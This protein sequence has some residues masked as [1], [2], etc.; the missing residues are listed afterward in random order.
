MEVTSLHCY[1]NDDTLLKAALMNMIASFPPVGAILPVKRVLIPRYCKFVMD[2][3]KSSTCS[4]PLFVSLLLDIVS[5]WPSYAED[6]ETIGPV[7]EA[8]NAGKERDKVCCLIHF[9]FRNVELLHGKRLVERMLGFITI[10]R[11]GLSESE[12]EDAL[13]T[14][15]DVLDDVRCSY[16]LL[17][18][19]NISSVSHPLSLK[20]YPLV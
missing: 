15:D 6:S 16:L 18:I 8:L 12:L 9:I 4:N 20:L 5:Q 7:M 17:S 14:C 13:S 19:S 2:M 11:D 1:G 10:S 3:I